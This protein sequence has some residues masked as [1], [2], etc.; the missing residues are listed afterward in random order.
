MEGLK[1]QNSVWLAD[2]LGITLN[3]LEKRRCYFPHTLP[4]HYKVGRRVLYREDEVFEWLTS[5][6]VSN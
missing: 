1:F 6:K 3:A 5:C 2:L 4:A